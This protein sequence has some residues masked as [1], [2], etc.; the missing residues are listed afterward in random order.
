MPQPRPDWAP[1]GVDL[2]KPSAA[3][4]YDYYLGGAHNFEVD[5]RLARQALELIPDGPLLMQANR[6]FLHRAVRYLIEQGITQFIDVGSGIPTRGNVHETV[7]Q[8]L[9]DGS[10]RVLYVDH[11]PV[12]VAHSELILGADHP[13]VRVLQAD[14]RQ[15]QVILESAQRRELIDLSRP[16][17]VL[18]VAVLHF[19]SEDD[20][21]EGVIGQFE[22]AVAPGSFLVISHG[23]AEKQPQQAAKVAQLYRSSADQATYRTRSRVRELVDGWDLV[24]PGLV[25]V[26][27]W[28]PAWP[29]WPETPGAPTETD[30][31]DWAAVV[32]RKPES[33]ATG[34]D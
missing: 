9:P 6:A 4:M 29:A 31:N 22:A 20:D 2:T 24:E 8:A 7:A 34:G 1:E 25:W 19:V 11:D 21:P 16:V 26:P 23:T 14:L 27:E 10:G 33:P 17:G 28:R 13:G 12:A 30:I 32:A 15:P 5:R 3:R 18:M